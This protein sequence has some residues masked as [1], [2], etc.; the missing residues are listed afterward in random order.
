M[1][2]ITVSTRIFMR[3]I[4]YLAIG[5]SQYCILRVANVDNDVARRPQQLPT[6]L[7]GSIPLRVRLE[8]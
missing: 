1:N 2:T 5:A 6:A 7:R 8:H 3:P 4:L